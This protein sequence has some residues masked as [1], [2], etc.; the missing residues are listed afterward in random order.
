MRDFFALIFLTFILAFIA[1]P[2]T[3][4]GE[5]FLHLGRRLAV[6]LVYVLYLS[7]VVSFVVYL[8]RASK[9]SQHPA[10]FVRPDEAR[11]NALKTELVGKYPSLHPL[12][13]GYLRSI[14]PDEVEQRASAGAATAM[15]AQAAP[16]A[17]GAKSPAA[18]GG[19]SAASASKQ[20]K[21]N[22]R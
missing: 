12:I 19:G 6:I 17:Q 2:L 3:R 15:T 18:S 8:T 21:R 5:R 20:K 7:A 14:L 4:F 13:I 9:R 11:L 1:M 16:A 22:R 10:R